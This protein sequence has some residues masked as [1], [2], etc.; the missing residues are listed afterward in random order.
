MAAVLKELKSMFLMSN[1]MSYYYFKTGFKKNKF[2]MLIT[3]ISI[4]ESI[5]FWAWE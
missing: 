5:F 3:Q 2:R 4:F 1:T